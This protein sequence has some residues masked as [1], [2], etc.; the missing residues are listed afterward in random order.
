VQAAPRRIAGD[1]R[2]IDAAAD[3]GEVILGH[4]GDSFRD[5]S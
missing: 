2:S 5:R 4:G 3:H 1:A